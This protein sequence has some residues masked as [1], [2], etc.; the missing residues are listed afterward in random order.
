M[1]TVSTYIVT[2]R[3]LTAPRQEWQRLIAADRAAAK[4]LV[5]VLEEYGFEAYVEPQ[6]SPQVE[7]HHEP[8]G[9][10]PALA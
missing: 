1:D 5:G 3:H 7:L 2:Y 8:D 6:P 9:N 4:T 10:T